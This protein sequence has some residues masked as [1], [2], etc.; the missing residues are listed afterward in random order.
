M[1]VPN[2]PPTP[3]TAKTSNVSSILHLLRTK[4][5]ASWQPTPAIAPMIKA[6]TGPTKPDAGVMDARPAI[7]PVTI[8][9]KDA[10]PNLIRS[11]SAHVSD[12]VAAEICVTVIAI[13]A[14]PS[15]ASCE[16]PLK[17]NQPTHNRAAP[18]ITMPGLC[19]G[20][21]WFLRAPKKTARTS[22]AIPAVS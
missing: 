4:F 5:T 18:I 22:A 16:P 2:I 17:P 15:A 11:H 3:C 1:M 9:T 6:S 14:P 12:A 20:V 8:P 21:F 13:A 10:R 19:G 7:V